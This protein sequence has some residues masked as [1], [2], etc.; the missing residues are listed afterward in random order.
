VSLILRYYAECRY[1]DCHYPE[2]RYAECR[3]AE[4]R[5]AKRRYA[6]C[7]CAECRYAESR[8]AIFS[9]ACS[10]LVPRFCLSLKHGEMKKL[11]W[12]KI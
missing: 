6:K 9:L 10:A 12:D 1:A 7:R 11:G 3:Y 5:Y 2:C 8:G 4:C